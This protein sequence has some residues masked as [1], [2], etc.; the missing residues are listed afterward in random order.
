MILS[1]GREIFQRREKESEAARIGNETPFG[2]PETG[3]GDE[4]HFGRPETCWQRGQLTR[5]AERTNDGQRACS[6]TE[7]R[8]GRGD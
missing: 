6:Q 4:N 7:G 2:Q 1:N 5:F 8:T 3:I